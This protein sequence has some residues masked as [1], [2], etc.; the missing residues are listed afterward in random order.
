MAENTQNEIPFTDKLT[1]L[2]REL[3][4]Y[5]SLSGHEEPVAAI[6]EKFFI[7][8]KPDRIYRKLGGQGIAFEFTGKSPGKTLMFRSD[9]DA[10]P[11][12]EDTSL[13]WSSKIEGVSHKC[14]HDGHMAIL[15]GLGQLI[16]NDRPDNGRCILLF[17]PE[18]ETGNGAKKV[19]ED[20]Q[21]DSIRPDLI[22]GLHNLPGFPAGTILLKEGTFAAA[23]RGMIIRL[24]GRTAHAGQPET[25]ISPVPAIVKLT[26]FVNEELTLGDYSGFVLAT[27]IHIRVG[28]RAFGTAPGEAEFLITL[29]AF[30]NNDIEKLADRMEQKVRS[31]AAEHKLHFNITWTEIFPA[32]VNHENAGRILA[33]TAREGGF[34]IRNLGKVFRWSE[35]F[36][37][38]LQEIEGAFFG[39]G[40]GTDVPQLHNPDYDFPDDIMPEGIRFFF[41]LYRKT[42]KSG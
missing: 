40:A 12:R 36:G 14:G 32:T 23:S 41:E 7:P 26:Q 20:S 28:E 30:R 9:L 19:L 15:S 11:I 29:R 31:V 17:Q 5:P 42:L 22:F 37:Y 1:G 6:L 21:F 33:E 38:Y 10:L 16:S 24:T 27:I 39:L 4:R 25:G 13:Q 8:L 3:H 35:D 18:E 34:M 2:R